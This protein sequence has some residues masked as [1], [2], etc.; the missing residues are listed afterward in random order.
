MCC[1]EFF[2]FLLFRNRPG[3]GY[4]S[5]SIEKESPAKKFFKV[6]KYEPYRGASIPKVAG[7]N[8]AV[9]RQIFQPAQCGLH[10]E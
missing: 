7:S 5:V 2:V 4:D 3:G 1:L 8:P 6:G 9:A 10:S